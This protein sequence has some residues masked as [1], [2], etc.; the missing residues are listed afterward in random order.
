MKLFIDTNVWLRF[1]LGEGN[2][3]QHCVSLFEKIEKGQIKPYAST[4]VLL[5]IHFVLTKLYRIPSKQV[6]ADIETILK[7]TKLTPY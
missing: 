6:I 5:E 4:I 3:Y 7:T 2:L 1:I